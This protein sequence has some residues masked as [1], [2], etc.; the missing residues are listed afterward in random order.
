M[1]KKKEV[2]DGQWVKPGAVMAPYTQLIADTGM[3]VKQHL[4]KGLE[5]Y[6]QLGKKVAELTADT[7]KYGQQSIEKFS[8][9]LEKM[10]HISLGI[11]ALYDA[12]KIHKCFSKEQLELAKES[13]MAIRRMLPMCT[14]SVTPEVRQNL[15]EAAKNHTGPSPF[16]VETAIAKQLGKPAPSKSKED[17]QDTLNL[18]KAIKRV[19][20][21]ERMFS[22]IETKIKDL[23]DCVKLICSEDDVSAM[24]SANASWR[25]ALDAFESLKDTWVSQ[26]VKATNALAKVKEVLGK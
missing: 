1:S 17:D 23:G 22:V 4:K 13:N 21:A 26:V 7:E 5:F 8:A 2:L 24:Q 12:Q 16:D 3:L 15:L 14:R 18:K 19:K 25:E 10:E 20:G 11:D 9:D 6:W